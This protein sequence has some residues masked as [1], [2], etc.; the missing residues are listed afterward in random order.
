ME[1]IY[2]LEVR[3]N[4]SQFLHMESS[5]AFSMTLVFIFVCVLYF[6]F[7]HF[8]LIMLYKMLSTINAMQDINDQ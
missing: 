6:F 8:C 7:Y 1:G 2:G 3:V 5:L 4:R